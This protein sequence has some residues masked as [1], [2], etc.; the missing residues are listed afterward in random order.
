MS[1][2]ANHPASANGQSSLKPRAASKTS[3]PGDWYLREELRVRGVSTAEDLRRI[4]NSKRVKVAG[5]VIV[6]QRPHTAKEIVFLSLEDETGVSNIIVWPDLF[7]K[8]RLLWTTAPFELIEGIV[9]KQDDVIHVKAESVQPL[10]GP[11][12]APESHDFH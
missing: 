8:Y 5:V 2:A 3:P 1:T 11:Q 10:H 12:H 7:E 6:R 4:R 9:Q